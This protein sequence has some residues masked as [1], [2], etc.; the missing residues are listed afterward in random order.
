MYA[1]ICNAITETQLIEAVEQKTVLPT[2]NQCCK[3][4]VEEVLE[5]FGWSTIEN[6]NKEIQN[7]DS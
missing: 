2:G 3:F 7:Q 4:Y 6:Y 1:C 5:N